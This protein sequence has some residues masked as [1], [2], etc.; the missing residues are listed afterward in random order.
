[1]M[2]AT[3]EPMSPQKMP[4]EIRI[5]ACSDT[6]CVRTNNEDSYRVVPN[7]NLF[8]LSDGMGGL[9]FGEVASRL[10]VE[11]VAEHVREAQKN[12][13]TPLIGARLEG[14]S[15]TG[16]RLA[17][18]IRYANHAVHITALRAE[19]PTP[20]GATIVAVQ[21]TDGRMSV[22]HVGDSRVYRLRNGNF[23]QLTHDHSFVAEQV[24]AGRMTTEQAN[25]SNL[26][27]VLIRALGIDPTVQ[28]D[29]SEEA[30]TD[31]DTI[32]LC[33]DGLTR[34][35][36]DA[37]IA[38]VLRDRKDAESAAQGLID[39]AKQAG[40]A[41]NITVIVARPGRKPVSAFARFGKWFR[42]SA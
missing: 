31:N 39:L 24:R 33:S 23:E 1:M 12:P 7:L 19:N 34:E 4:L 9:Q 26:Q 30:V 27:N 18:A 28:V 29:V 14:V 17:S 11:A 8:L 16:N 32:L 41:D 36:S 21:L 6:G 10:A 22:A 38:N 13:A 15:E 25:A 42:R 35:L 3:A 37:Q 40:G 2:A 20:M 5:G